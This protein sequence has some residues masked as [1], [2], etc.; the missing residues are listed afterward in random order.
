MKHQE[1]TDPL[2]TVQQNM[3]TQKG[4]DHLCGAC[5]VSLYDSIHCLKIRIQNASFLLSIQAV[6]SLECLA[7]FMECSGRWGCSP[8][9]DTSLNQAIAVVKT[10]STACSIWIS[11]NSFYQGIYIIYFIWSECQS[12]RE[13]NVW[14]HLRI[15]QRFLESC[16]KQLSCCVSV[17]KVHFLG[18]IF[19]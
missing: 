18:K 10:L 19:Q 12:R 3:G 6:T 4:P 14:A 5:V 7:L 2:W 8:I 15:I 9:W 11:C 16:L 13:G 1:I 17:L